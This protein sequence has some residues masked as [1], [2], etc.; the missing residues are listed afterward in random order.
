M[1]MPWTLLGAMA[2]VASGIVAGRSTAGGEPQEGA[3]MPGEACIDTHA[4][5]KALTANAWS[6]KGTGMWDSVGKVSFRLGAGKT[7]LVQDYAATGT[8]GD[9]LHGLG[10]LKWAPDGKTA[11]VW[12]FDDTM[13]R[14]IELK[15]P[16]SESGYELTGEMALPDGKPSTATFKL[17]K[18]GEGFEFTLAADGQVM[19]TEVYS[20]AK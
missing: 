3:G 14:P 11:T 16:A 18:K 13:K 5:V 19:M 6:T 10:V 8:A 17:A 9:A 2:L 4:L 15:G 7:L 12:W 20:K 1:R